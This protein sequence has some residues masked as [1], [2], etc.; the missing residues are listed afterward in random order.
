MKGVDLELGIR[1]FHG[2]ELASSPRGLAPA[3]A[4][5]RRRA[6]PAQHNACHAAHR[7]ARGNP[8][9]ERDFLDTD[10][11]ASSKRRRRNLE[12]G[13]PVISRCAAPHRRSAAPRGEPLSTGVRA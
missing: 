7:G 9:H 1:S 4:V 10:Y 5:E 3:L 2:N 6:G 13:A 11:S 12:R 8:G